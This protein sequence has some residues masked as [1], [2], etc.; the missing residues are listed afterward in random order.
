MG[1]P[2]LGSRDHSRR[3]TL[4]VLCTVL[5]V[6]FLDKC[7]RPST[8]S[9]PRCAPRSPT[10]PRPRDIEAAATRIENAARDA[11]PELGKFFLDPTSRA[12]WRR[13]CA[14]TDNERTRDHNE[15]THTDTERSRTGNERGRATHQH[16]GSDSS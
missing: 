7:G 2:A 5:F 6:T 10:T 13:A 16:T 1:E 12:D 11:V 9:S 4:A 15:R 3:A 8:A 14:D